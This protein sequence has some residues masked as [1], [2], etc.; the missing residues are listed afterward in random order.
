MQVK[1]CSDFVRKQWC[2]VQHVHF[3][4]QLLSSL[5]VLLF[6]PNFLLSA[7]QSPEQIPDGSPVEFTD[8]AV[9]CYSRSYSGLPL[10]KNMAGLVSKRFMK[11][12]NVVK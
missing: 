5:A 11:V 4:C 8:T 10:V 12:Y 6:A 7:S 2:N 1:R 9:K 3:F